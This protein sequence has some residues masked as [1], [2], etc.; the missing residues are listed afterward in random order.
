MSDLYIVWVDC[1]L[2]S[3][4]VYQNEYHDPKDYI[5]EVDLIKQYKDMFVL[6]AIKK[7][8]W[9]PLGNYEAKFNNGEAGDSITMPDILYDYIQIVPASLIHFMQRLLAAE[10]DP[11]SIDLTSMV[12][13]VDTVLNSYTEPQ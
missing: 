5:R 2:W 3:K 9:I 1:N 11:A 12:Q 6:T 7:G 13:N 10:C 4:V 8:N